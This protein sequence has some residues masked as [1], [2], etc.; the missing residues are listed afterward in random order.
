MP[1]QLYYMDISSPCRS[2]MLVAEA[3]G[4]EL[5]LIETNILIGEHLTPEYEQVCEIDMHLRCYC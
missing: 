4:L 2:V 1:I 5:E 3:I